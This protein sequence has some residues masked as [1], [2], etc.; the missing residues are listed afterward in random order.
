MFGVND[1]VDRD[2][3]AYLDRSIRKSNYESGTAAS[4]GYTEVACALRRSARVAGAVAPLPQPLVR[5]V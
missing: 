5:Q 3:M 1:D 2:E 4:V